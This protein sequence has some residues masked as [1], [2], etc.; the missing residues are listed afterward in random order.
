MILVTTVSTRVIGI[1]AK[2]IFVPAIIVGTLVPTNIVGTL[3]PTKIVGTLVPTKIVGTAV[4][5][6]IVLTAYFW[7]S[8]Q[9]DSI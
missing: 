9:Q 8:C 6:I 5:T 2:E 7:K 1:A 3:V 4:Q